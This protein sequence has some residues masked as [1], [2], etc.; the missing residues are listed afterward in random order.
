MRK[1]PPDPSIKNRNTILLGQMCKT[2][3]PRAFYTNLREVGR[4]AS[5]TVY[6]AS[7]IADDELVAIKVVKD[8]GKHLFVNELTLMRKLKHKN[9]INLLDSY[10]VSEQEELWLVLDYIDGSSLTDVVTE[11]VMREPQIAYVTHQVLQGIQYLHQNEVI[12]R[13]IKSDNVLVSYNGDVK[14]IDFGFSTELIERSSRTTMVGTPYWMAPEI[15]KKEK[16]SKK[17]DI[18]ALGIM[19][20]EM[21]N[22]E[23]PYLGE[24][25]LKALFLIVT[26]GRP[27]IDFSDKSD[28]L[29]D[30][31]ME[32]CL[33]VNVDERATVDDLM[34]HPFLKVQA[35]PKSIGPLIKAAKNRIHGGL[36]M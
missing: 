25:Q 9:L 27:K 12:H 31:V 14:V 36:N 30:F 35:D 18:W 10:W 28:N 15:A 11:T 5:A 1:H 6:T 13:D 32:K 23:P 7:R 26:N 20:L 2:D 29:K 8:V 34:G 21:I 19:V 22:G 17:V 3:Y 16:Y 4:G 33:V 24:T